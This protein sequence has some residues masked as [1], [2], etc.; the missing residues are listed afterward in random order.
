MK[1][2][3]LAAGRSSRMAPIRDKNLLRFG[4]ETLLLKL[5]KNAHAAGCHDFVIVGNQDN[6]KFIQQ[7]C[8]QHDFL[9]DAQVTTQP[10]LDEGM[11]GGILAGL[12]FIDDDEPVLIHNGNDWVEPR[13]IE[14]VVESVHSSD[15][16]ILGQ[17]RA[18][19]FP[20][21]Y[22]EADDGGKILSIIEKP[23]E[24]HEPSD[25]VNIVV[26]GFARAGDLKAAL[27]DASSDD[28]DIYE[29]ALDRLFKTKNFQAVQYDGVWQAI[30]YP[31]HV[32]EMMDVFLQTS[33]ST[34]ETQDYNEVQPGIWV[35]Q[36]AEVSDKATLKGENVVIDAGVK[37]F[38]NAVVS[39][40][41]YVGPNSIVGNN[42]LVRHSNIGPNCQVGFNSEVA[43]SWLSGNVTAH[44]A[45]IG[46]SVIGE[47]VNFGAYSCTANLRLDRKTVKV[48]IKDEKVDS[49]HT[50]LGAIVGHGT[51]IGIGAKLMPGCKTDVETLVRPG[52]I[53][54]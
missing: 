2:I 50:K 41:A 1:T 4:G 8:Q 38:E 35:H 47:D 26:H 13:A 46:D 6:L 43:R 3:F 40:P 14:A 52:E 12:E 9:N 31:W 32:L 22:L 21:G 49:K 48:N 44:I 27:A 18:E 7:T 5:L 16:A 39:G 51:Q 10:N 19:Y 20:G 34:L 53:W 11:A 33:D 45:Y 17:K 30:K 54:Y 37:I 28:D 25:L 42:A 36:T 15:G 29:V 24:G 23:G